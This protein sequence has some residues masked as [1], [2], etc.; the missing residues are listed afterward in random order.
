[1]SNKFIYVTDINH[2]TLLNGTEI[3]LNID[4][5]ST[6]TIGTNVCI[7]LVNGTHGEHTGLYTISLYDFEKIKKEIVIING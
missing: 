1:M 5:I 4:N 7:I 2:R 3:L 6:I